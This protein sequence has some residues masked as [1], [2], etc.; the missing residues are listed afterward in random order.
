MALNLTDLNIEMAEVGT[1][2][3]HP[4]LLVRSSSV[5]ALYHASVRVTPTPISDILYFSI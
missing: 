1:M 5:A 4:Y 2:T 3:V